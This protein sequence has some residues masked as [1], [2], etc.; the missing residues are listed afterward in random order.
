[1]PD[2]RA[3]VNHRAA[4]VPSLIT[5]SDT[6][7]RVVLLEQI[8]MRFASAPSIVSLALSLLVGCGGGRTAATP[9]TAPAP[10]RRPLAALA[11]TGAIVAP[12]SMVHFA[13]ELSS[14]A[15]QPGAR[16]LLHALDDDIAAALADRGLKANWVMP[17]DLA[18]SY[19]R[20]PTYATDPYALAEESLRSSAVTVGSRLPEPLASQLR[21]MIALHENARAVLLPVE[22]RFER[23][24]ATSSTGSARATLRLVLVDP[25]FS[26]TRWV[27]TV[28]SDTTS[29]DARVLTRALARG[30]ADLIVSRQ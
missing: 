20:N 17:A 5:L 4:F 11:A 2:G 23:A 3:R 13:P 14:T 8:S 18:L 19:K 12:T 28:T 6:R 15:P 24:D 10:E 25:R 16:E 29:P 26:E 1:M 30:V 9:S 22:L 21:T 27:G 7:S